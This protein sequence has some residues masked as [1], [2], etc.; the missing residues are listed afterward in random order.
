MEEAAFWLMRKGYVIREVRNATER[1][2]QIEKFRKLQR[3]LA[4]SGTE[5]LKDA[6]WVAEAPKRSFPWI[7]L[8][9]LVVILLIV[10]YLLRGS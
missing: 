9:A 7:L 2:L 5:P 6:T 1:D 4:G 3:R 8:F 10:A